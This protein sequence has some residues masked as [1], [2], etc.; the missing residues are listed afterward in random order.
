MELQRARESMNEIDRHDGNLSDFSHELDQEL[1]NFRE[2]DPRCVA[3]KTTIARISNP[4]SKE[5]LTTTL[6][7]TR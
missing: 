4:E 3:L 2:E 6:A 5:K 1:L 7:E